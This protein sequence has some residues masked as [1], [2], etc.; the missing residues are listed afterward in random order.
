MNLNRLEPYRFIF[1][2]PTTVEAATEAALLLE[3]GLLEA[4]Q[5]GPGRGYTQVRPV[6]YWTVLTTLN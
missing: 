5:D 1:P 3:L 2:Q 6:C 4:E